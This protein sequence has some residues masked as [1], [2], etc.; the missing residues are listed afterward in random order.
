MSSTLRVI[1]AAL[2]LRE[3]YGGPARSIP[4]L[5]DALAAEHAQVDLVTAANAA[6]GDPLIL[7]RDPRVHVTQLSVVFDAKGLALWAPRFKHAVI[8]RA[9]AGGAVVL[10]D[11]GMWRATNHAMSEAAHSLR[12]PLLVSP[13]GMLEG[14]AR[15]HRAMRKRVA[16]RLWARRDLARAR[17]LHA[18]STIEADTLL[19]LGLNVPV[20]V[21]PNG[22]AIPLDA[23]AAHPA[24]AERVL[25]FLGRLHAVKGL[26]LLVE[27][28]RRAAPS[29]WRLV[30]AGPSEDGYG[31][32][33]ARAIATANVGH[34]VTLAGALGPVAAQRAIADADVLVLPSLTE[35]FGGV[36]AEALAAARPVIATTTTPWSALTREQCGW[37][38]DPTP[39]A[40]ADVITLACARSDDATRAAMGAR[41]RAYAQAHL[42][43][44]HVA[45]EMLA[46]YRW[47]LGSGTTPSTVRRA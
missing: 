5:A 37:L 4:A 36:V 39:D 2:S 46:V 10:H 3:S 33:L 24:R 14:A 6:P 18:T 42:S 8:E 22:V 44:Q 29:G 7:P 40:L 13:R 27:A 11:H 16:W 34:S 1:H 17:C 25:L 43:W 41:G 45:R 23:P 21:I 28:W 20:A 19:A 26:T 47:L 31:D 15:E 38:A 32:V 30:I 9:A 35:S 12:V